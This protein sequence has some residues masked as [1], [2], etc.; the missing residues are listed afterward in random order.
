VS[1]HVTYTLA[2]LEVDL[3]SR[4]KEE[5]SISLNRWGL[6]SSGVKRKHRTRRIG[7]GHTISRIVDGN[8]R[9]GVGEGSCKSGRGELMTRSP[10]D[11][12]EERR[13]RS[14]CGRGDQQQTRP[15]GTFRGGD[16]PI[17]VSVIGPVRWGSGDLT[18]GNC[19]NHTLNVCSV[20]SLLGIICWAKP[21]PQEIPCIM[22]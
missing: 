22:Y 9:Y 12:E 8:W 6:W 3:N 15:K 18:G 5:V 4:R 14:V 11:G 17:R 7:V 21:Q 20:C 16:V 13:K 10:G 2:G 1:L 19:A